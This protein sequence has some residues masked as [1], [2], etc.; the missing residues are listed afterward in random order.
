MEVQWGKA[1]SCRYL[2]ITSVLH[3]TNKKRETHDWT[4]ERAAGVKKWLAASLVL[5]SLLLCSLVFFL[6]RS[7]FHGNLNFMADSLTGKLSGLRHMNGNMIISIRLKSTWKNVFQ[8]RLLFVYKRVQNVLER[9]FA[10]EKNNR[11]M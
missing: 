7:H 2:L 4:G 11:L 3:A 9:A 10:A 8:S 5:W 1:C 6:Y